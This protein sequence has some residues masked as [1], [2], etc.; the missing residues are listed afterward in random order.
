MINRVERFLKQVRQDPDDILAHYNLG[1]F[2]NEDGR[3][4]E[5][6]VEYEKALELDT[7]RQYSTIIHS[8]LGSLY[9]RDYRLEEAITE[10]E[11]GIEDLPLLKEENNLRLIDA[12]SIYNNLGLA[13]LRKTEEK[14]M[15]GNEERDLNKARESFGK[16]LEFNPNYISAK[17]NFELIGK[18]IEYG[19]GVS[20]G[21]GRLIKYFA[22]TRGLSS[23]E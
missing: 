13:L 10:F 3:I 23:Y 16:T 1:I 12:A 15:Y 19:W 5:S 4:N 6:V 14:E 22:G 17:D 20:D 7:N 11:L 8:N 18:M 2:L 21:E 9:Y